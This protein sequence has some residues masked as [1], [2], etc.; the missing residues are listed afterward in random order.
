[1]IGQISGTTTYV[2]SENGLPIVGLTLTYIALG[3]GITGY[4][5]A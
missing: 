4:M 5:Q 2:E 1:M 3:I